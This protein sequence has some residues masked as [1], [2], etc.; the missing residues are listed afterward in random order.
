MKVEARTRGRRSDARRNRAA[1]VEAAAHELR[2]G[3]ELNMQSVAAAAA[4]SRST[5]YRHF[6][7][8]T[9][10]EDALLQ[11]ALHEARE[12]AQGTSSERRPPLALLR[13][14]IGGLARVARE[15]RLD[16]LG[17]R[18][19]GGEVGELADATLPL[20]ERLRESAELAPAPPHDWLAQVTRHF[21]SACLDLGATGDDHDAVT[22]ALFRAL[23]EPLDRG[24][25]VL[26]AE[27][28][29]L[30]INPRAA[31]MFDPGGH[32]EVG[33]RLT[34]PRAEV[35]YEDG[36]PCPAGR[37]PLELAVRSGQSQKAV[38]GHR[39]PGGEVTWLTIEARVL[40]A[41][42][43]GAVYGV[44]G[45][46]N[47][48]TT[49]KR[50][51]LEHL[52]PAGQLAGLQP[53]PIDVVRILDEIPPHLFAEQFVLEARRITGSPV[54]LYVLDIDGT[55]LLRLSGPEEFPDRLGAPLA[56]GPEM[57]E[58]GIPEL[59]ARLESELP[60]VSMAPMWLRGRAIGLLLALRAPAGR[61]DELA[62][63]GAAAMEL[64]GGYTDVFDAARR[65]KETVPAA[66]LQQSL[67]PPRIAR[68]GSGVLAGSVL[69]SYDVGGDWFDYVENRDGAWIAIADA[70]GKGATAAALGSIALAALRAARR[71]N[72]S[73]EEAA[74]TMHEVVYDVAR[75]EFFVTAI[76]A[77][78]HPVYSSFSWINCGHPP[79]LVV[80]ADNTVEQ[81]SAEPGLPLGIFERERRF[82][83]RQR[84][85]ED[86]ELL[87]LHSDGITARKT[88]DG[89]FGVDGIERA[90]R[91]ADSRSATE[92]AVA[93]QEAVMSAAEDPLQD[94]AVAIVLAPD[95]QGHSG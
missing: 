46:L 29:L 35:V 81:L 41:P 17:A 87:I 72:Q 38:R 70:A 1:I 65:R 79:P 47:D 39:E 24:L 14:L 68:I 54:A 16:V 69:P 67:L 11:Q 28:G 33:E 55:H 84:R 66:E 7:T 20:E 75:P 52:R 31:G 25:V 74:Q 50:R 6:P 60:G 13:Q 36:S 19:L 90:I 26:D 89:L 21:V 56:L 59:R 58:D 73:L 34:G 37:Y 12:L 43:G 91:A 53:V 83:R 61:L 49:E 8:R 57:A 71:S 3:S 27:G 94:D 51:E 15:Y 62:R 4:V 48:V 44:V 88:P 92:I 86:N 77:R 2:L 85:L 82:S 80:H 42:G 63:H 22:D 93:I 78:W 18:A 40:R 45:V 10:L 76:I 30:C 95:Q 9:A 64:A 32:V 5:L 23:T